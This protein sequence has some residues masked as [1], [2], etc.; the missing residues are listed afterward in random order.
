MAK[1][2]PAPGDDRTETWDKVDRVVMAFENAWRLGK[3]PAIEHYLKDAAEERQALLR[4]LALVDLERR[5]KAGQTARVE[6]YLQRFAALAADP[7]AVLDLIA[8]EYEQ[9]RRKQDAAT[10]RAELL[11]RFPA[12]RQALAARLEG[13]DAAATFIV[14]GADL[15]TAAPVATQV[16]PTVAQLVTA[17]RQGH[18][19]KQAQLEKLT[20]LQHRFPK[21]ADLRS[22]LVRCG[23]L[24]PYQAQE[25]SQ[26]RGASLVVGPYVLLEPLGV[27]GMG[28][29]FK[30]RHRLMNRLAAVKLIREESRSSSEFQQRFLRE[31]EAAAQL[32]HPNIVAAFD[33]AQHGPSMYLAMEYV[34]GVD[35]ARLLKAHGPLPVARACDYIRQ[36]ALGLQHAHER[37]LSHRDVKPSNLLLA[38]GGP[39][40]PER[41]LAPAESL[42][43]VAGTIK[44]LDL[45]LARFQFE[46]DDE[47]RLTR[48]GDVM[49]TPD[50]IAPEQ[51]VDTRRADIRSDIYSLGC[52]LYELLAGRPPFATGSI[53]EKLL[54]HQTCQ[55]AALEQMRP[56]VQSALA[57][58][59]RRMMAKRPEDRYQTPGEVAAA[60]APFGAAL[61]AIPLGFPAGAVRGP[62]VAPTARPVPV[63]MAARTEPGSAPR[64]R[65][66]RWL[67]A[68]VAGG[69]TLVLLSI[70]LF[71]PRGQGANETDKKELPPP[72]VVSLLDR[73]RPQDI[74]FELRWAGQPKELVAI[75]G[76]T[77]PQA[78]QVTNVLFCPDGKH[79]LSGCSGNETSATVR[80]WSLETMQPVYHIHPGKAAA[81]IA[82]TS[83]GKRAAAMG[84][85]PLLLG[86]DLATGKELFR[87]NGWQFCYDLRFSLD[88]RWLL[89]DQNPVSTGVRQD[90]TVLILNGAT[91][92][93][94]AAFQESKSPFLRSIQLFK[95]GK[96]AVSA[97]ILL[98]SREPA[99]ISFFEVPSGKPIK[100]WTYKEGGFAKICLSP[101]NRYLYG[102][103]EKDGHLWIW[104][105]KRPKAE[106]IRKP[107]SKTPTLSMAL[108][109]DGHSLFT[110]APTDSKLIEWAVPAGKKLREWPI[111]NV[112]SWSHVLDVAPD[113][114]HIAVGRADGRILI[115]RLKEAAKPAP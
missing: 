68:A 10:V 102:A 58:V 64:R 43:P 24:T 19:L 11:R 42:S 3:Q 17:L 110:I 63:A 91:G 83:D 5:L 80:L 100:A 14:Q 57:Q 93:K 29:V 90:S 31:V 44:V 20:D 88:G 25:I 33:A 8:L 69:A 94:H 40:S 7:Q 54:A 75:L 108:S 79:L 98:T 9:R 2:G 113:G 82:V 18:L 30:A 6:A 13:E 38:S 4:E 47:R 112:P 92:A 52:T 48:V 97:S 60:L 32:A 84:F 78:G 1:A 111:M 71:R 56:E 76:A 109:P 106:P 65:P 77:S 23:W 35:L 50:Y 62:V 53:E 87:K 26:G 104:D 36:A 99:S 12:Y 46:S 105:L 49:G 115:L 37:G 74:P 16:T 41:A 27:G 34:D 101:D 21:A 85:K 22:E 96:T 66:R 39:A 89:G 72:P 103:H 28:Q 73:L 86:W 61:T 107:A 55:P 45:G 114:R 67:W 95:D 51:V 70:W 81:C 59:V 15:G